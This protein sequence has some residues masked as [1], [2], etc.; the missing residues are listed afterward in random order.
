MQAIVLQVKE[1]LGFVQA[2]IPYSESSLVQDC[3]DFGRVLKVEYREDGILVI[4]EL[5]AEMRGKL[6]RYEITDRQ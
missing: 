2:L 6:A 5:I 4:A 3:Y 1:L